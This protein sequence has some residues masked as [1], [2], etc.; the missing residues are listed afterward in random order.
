MRGYHPFVRRAAALLAV[1][2]LLGGGGT[3]WAASATLTIGV[4]AGNSITISVTPAS[5]TLV[6]DPVSPGADW[7][8]VT[9]PPAWWPAGVSDGF[10]YTPG[11]SSGCVSVHIRTF[12]ASHTVTAALSLSP[13]TA[14]LNVYLAPSGSSTSC[15]TPTA[16]AVQVTTAGITLVSNDTANN[17]TLLYYLLVQPVNDQ[18]VSGST[19]IT[20]TFTAQ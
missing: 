13:T 18:P 9:T 6:E 16:T 7:T 15:T 4:T 5:E 8:F 20:L 3:A 10:V 11:G 19:T 12:K 17:E 1:L 14:P 2:V